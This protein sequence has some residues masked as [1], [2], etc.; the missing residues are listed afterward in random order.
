MRFSEAWLRE[1][2]NPPVDTAALAE[3]LSMAGLEVDA[4]TPAAPPFQGVQIGLV[5]EVQ[6]HPDAAKLRICQVDLGQGETR[7]II[8]G[9]PN[10][11]A[12]QRVPVATLG[13]VLPGGLKIKRA[14]LRGVESQGMICSAA[15]LGLAETSEGILPLPADAPLGQDFRAWLGLDDVCIE[16]DLTPDRGDCLSL[17]GVAREVGVINRVP[18]CAPPLAPV[19]ATRDDRFPVELL[20][21]A[22]CPRYACRVVRNIDPAAETPLWM[23][24]RLRRSGLRAIHPVVDVT[25]YVLLELGQPLHGFDLAKLTGG[26]QVRLAG[27]G[28]SLALLNGETVELTADTLVIADTVQAVALAPTPPTASS[29]AWTPSSRSRP[30]NGPPPCC[31]KSPVASPV[32]SS[33]PSPWTSCRPAS[34]M[35]C[36]ASVSAASWV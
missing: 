18:V 28:E 14:K 8:C 9:A 1:W 33:R 2:V 29:A 31:C 21:P 35:S 6:P 5:R 13:A 15:E 3:Q 4:I 23:R 36:A 24:E 20:A 12:G 11:A 26:I 32:P 19:S 10:V 22:A 27:P 25:N 16:L 30:W 34:A 17:A 7:Q